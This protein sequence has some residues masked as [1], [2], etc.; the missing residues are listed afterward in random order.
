MRYPSQ[1]RQWIDNR[2]ANCPSGMTCEVENIGETYFQ[3]QNYVLKVR[4]LLGRTIWYPE[5]GGCDYLKKVC[6]Y[7]G[8][9][10]YYKSSM[11]FLKK[12]CSSFSEFFEAHFPGTY[13]DLKITQKLTCI[14]RIDGK[15]YYNQISVSNV[16][17]ELRKI[18]RYICK[19][20]NAV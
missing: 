11:K 19:G 5:G 2:V 16:N 9:K 15:T 7:T 4:R 1:I 20:Q 6:F 18:Y 8:A 17:Y 3:G 13:K 14:K 12:V 10:E